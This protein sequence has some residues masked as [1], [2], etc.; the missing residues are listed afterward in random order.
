[1]EESRD[2][3]WRNR[4][5]LVREYRRRTLRELAAMTGLTYEGIRYW[6]MKHGIARRKNRQRVKR[7]EICG[8][9]AP[10]KTIILRFYF[11]DRAYDVCD[12]CIENPKLGIVRIAELGEIRTD[13][14][15]LSSSTLD[16][17]ETSEAS[18]EAA[19]ALLE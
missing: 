18:P 4:E 6:L 10:D 17:E 9:R 1:M 7:C 16:A 5:W 2:K 15:S 13:E 11:G 8:K 14:S 12:Q 19:V 3:P